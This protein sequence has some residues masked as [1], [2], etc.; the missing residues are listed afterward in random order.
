[1]L[2]PLLIISLVLVILGVPFAKSRKNVPQHKPRSKSEDKVKTLIV[3]TEKAIRE[4]PEKKPEVLIVM[5]IMQGKLN[6]EEKSSFKKHYKDQG[7]NI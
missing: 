3:A 6:D 4:N 2:I 7:Y 5:S 1:M